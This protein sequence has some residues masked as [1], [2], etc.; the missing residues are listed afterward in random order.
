MPAPAAVEMLERVGVVPAARRARAY[1][2]ELS[3]G[4]RQRVMLAMA[5]V[6]RPR[7]LI[8]DE[9]TTALDVTT[10]AQILELLGDLQDEMGLALVII[11]HDLGVVAGVADRVLVMYAGRIV[12]EGPADRVFARA[13]HPYTRGSARVGAPR[14]RP[15]VDARGDP[16]ACRPTRRTSRRAVHSIRAARWPRSRVATTLPDLHVLDGRHAAACLVRRRGVGRRAYAVTALL[17]VE[18]LVEGVPGAWRC[19]CGR[20]TTCRSRSRR[21]RRSGWWGSRGAGSRRS[22]GSSCACSNPTAE[23]SVS[24]ALTLTRRS[25]QSLRSL[26]RRVQIVFQDP[27]SSLDPR[28]SARSIVAEPLQIAGRGKRETAQRVREVFELVGLGPEHERRYPHELSGGQRQRVGIA[29]ALVVEPAL[30]VLDEPVTALDGSIQAQILNLLVAPAGGAR[31]GLP[32]HRARPRGRPPPRRSDRGHAP[33]SHRRDGAHRGT[34]RRARAPVHAGAPVGVARSPIP[35][36]ERERQRIVL[37]GEHP[38]AHVAT[39]GVQLPYAVLA[40]RS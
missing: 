33:R 20:S 11:S 30:L 22:P 4:M 17:E 39:V 38:D 23:S 40:S 32:V 27:Y 6:N 9:P 25:R 12:E 3:G 7:V 1:P 8:A 16:R 24:T 13:G 5:L 37:T 34:V 35:S 2:H 31:S 15:A 29:R 21:V 26:R 36:A 10:Q 14:R 18:H 19:R 28:M